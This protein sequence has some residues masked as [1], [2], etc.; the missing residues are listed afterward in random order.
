MIDSDNT[1]VWAPNGFTIA[2]DEDPAVAL[3][4]ALCV[5]FAGMHEDLQNLQG[6]VSRLQEALR[7]RGAP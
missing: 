6:E 2:F 1:E 4:S 7:E 5:V 3:C